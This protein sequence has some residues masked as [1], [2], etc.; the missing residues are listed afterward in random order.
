LPSV[1]T[2]S[3]CGWF[4]T[5]ASF[6]LYHY[7]LVIV[8]ATDHKG[9]YLGFKES[10]AVG[11][12]MFVR[13]YASSDTFVDL[14][15]TAVANTWYFMALTRAA[16][17]NNLKGYVARVTDAALLTASGTPTTPTTSQNR[18]TIGHS[19]WGDDCP[20][21]I[22]A[23]KIWDGVALTQ[24]EIEQERWYYTPQRTSGLYLW[25]PFNDQSD[26]AFT[27]YS[28]NGRGWT[29]SGTV[30]QIKVDGP[31][32]AWGPSK[33]VRIFIPAATG[34]QTKTVA[35]AGVGEDAIGS[36]GVSLSISDAGVGTDL[37]SGP[38]VSLGIADS[39]AGEDALSA[40]LAALTVADAGTGTDALGAILA[41][42]AVADVNWFTT[43]N[44]FRELDRL[45]NDQTGP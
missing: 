1:T 26:S 10:G 5:P 13:E 30:V 43:E 21:T 3:V 40:I 20:A 24:A 23:L 31:P 7:P 35:D 4:K 44:L 32:I 39:G 14:G 38:A 29:E 19:E 12:N 25:S 8:Y 37:P 9:L 17:T 27:D 6:E 34:D 41:A 11:G 15:I 42:L 33:R 16:G 22:A 28:G 2:V 45:V 18:L 36:V